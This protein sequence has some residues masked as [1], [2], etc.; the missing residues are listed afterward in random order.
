VIISH[1]KDL[2]I[3]IT[4]DQVKAIIQNTAVDL[5]DDPTDNLDAGPDWDSHGRVDMLRAHGCEELFGK[6]F[7]ARQIEANVLRRL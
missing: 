7:D 6:S 2:N 5:P 4:G 3:P 1:A